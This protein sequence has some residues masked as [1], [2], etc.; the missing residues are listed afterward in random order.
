MGQNKGVVGTKCGEVNILDLFPASSE[1]TRLICDSTVYPDKVSFC[2]GDEENARIYAVHLTT[3][4]QSEIRRRISSLCV[5]R[6]EIKH[7]HIFAKQMCGQITCV[8]GYSF[9]GA[10]SQ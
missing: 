8:A 3:A 9:P 4:N 10:H 5:A 2:Y 6:N 7:C 1:M